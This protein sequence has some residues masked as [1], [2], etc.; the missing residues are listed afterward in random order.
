MDENAI[1]NYQEKRRARRAA[2]PTGTTAILRVDDVLELNLVND[3]SSCGMLTSHFYTGDPY[4]I[5][6]LV[7][8]III[9]IPPSEP[10]SGINHQ[11]SIE[12]GKIVRTFFD[13]NAQNYFYGV[14][15]VH[16]SPYLR[17]LIVNYTDEA[18]LHERK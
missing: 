10:N 4:D 8:D 13:E 15:F 18:L 6:S 9:N 1:L 5:D 7:S 2:T 12:R 11:F 3:I 14:E 17:E 16:A